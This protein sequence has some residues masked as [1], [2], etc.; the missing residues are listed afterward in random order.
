MIIG[1][2]FSSKLYDFFLL[3]SNSTS[4]LFA[5]NMALQYGFSPKGQNEEIW[6]PNELTVSEIYSL[7]KQNRKKSPV[8]GTAGFLFYTTHNGKKANKIEFYDYRSGGEIFTYYEFYFHSYDQSGDKITF[9]EKR[10]DEIKS[11]MIFVS[12][13]KL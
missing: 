4:P 3:D 6:N 5:G 9:R 12:L 8:E 2:I 7:Y 10:I 11:N 13:G 1:I